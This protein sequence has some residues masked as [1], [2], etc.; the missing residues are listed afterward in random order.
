M[1]ERLQC[2][3]GIDVAINIALCYGAIIHKGTK[4]Y[5]R[6]E[7]NAIHDRYRIEF[8]AI[9]FTFFDCETIQKI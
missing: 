9:N 1:I 3:G 6:K 7:I 8:T 2:L 4:E 5:T